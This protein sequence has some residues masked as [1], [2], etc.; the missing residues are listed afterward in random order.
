MNLSFFVLSTQELQRVHEE[1]RV[2]THEKWHNR[3]ELK[4]VFFELLDLGKIEYAT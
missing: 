2:N 3:C 1:S 4:L